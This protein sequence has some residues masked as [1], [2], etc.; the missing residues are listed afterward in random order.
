LQRDIG[1][2][3]E[4]GL[5][6]TEICERLG[7]SR[8]VV[9][10]VA[11]RAGRRSRPGRK[12]L[13]DWGAIRAYYEK[14][15]TVRECREHF[16]FSA[17]AW[18]QAVVRG[19]I[20]LRPRPD[21]VKHSHKTRRQ[22]ADL[23]GQ[24]KTQ[25]E[26]ARRLGIS[27]GTVAFHVRNLGIPPDERCARRY[28]WKEVQVAYDTGLSVRQCCERFGFSTATWSQAVR[29]G[30]VV[31]RPRQMPL[32]ELCKSG[33]KRGRYYLR[34]RLI[35]AGLKENRCEACGITEWLGN[36]LNMALHHMNGDGLDNR[37][38]NLQL[39]CPNCH[40]QTPN[41]GGRNGHR[42]K[43]AHLKLVQAK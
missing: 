11:L 19:D 22:V 14:G 41:Y 1:K 37:L 8:S 21:P 32:E 4:Q 15:N 35:A 42:R 34:Q 6:Q 38:E 26:I 3:L 31:A 9:S 5:R 27:K 20:V 7:V 40:A 17:G 2:L 23:L 24:G 10:R 18:D 13:Y 39:L 25:A 30:S 16:G 12:L 43:R 29:R 28:D 36:P 33:V